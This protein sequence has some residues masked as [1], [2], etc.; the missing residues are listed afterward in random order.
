MLGQFADLFATES[1]SL[2]AVVAV[3]NVGP[4][5][6][7][8]GLYPCAGDDEW[9]VVDIRGDEDFPDCAAFSTGPI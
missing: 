9:C 8:R 5:D 4:G 7:P 1:L 6:A 3:G 2:G